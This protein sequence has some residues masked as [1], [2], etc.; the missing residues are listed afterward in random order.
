VYFYRDSPVGSDSQFNPLT[1]FVNYGF[2]ALQVRRSFDEEDFQARWGQVWRNLWNPLGAIREEGGLRAF[3]NRQVLPVDPGALGEVGVMLPN[4]AL[5]LLGGG[6]LYRKNA[7]WL[8]TR[9]YPYPRTLAALLGMGSEVLQEVFEKK[10]TT[11]EDEV[12]D[13]WLFR[14]AG[15]LLFTWNPVARLAARELGMV[16]WP[17]QAVY[18]AGKGRFG[19]GGQSY[20]VRPAWRLSA[21][22]LPFVYFGMTTLAG[23]S[24]R[25]ASGDRVSWGGGAA[26]VDA[27]RTSAEVR[28]SAGLFWDRRGSL[29][30][31]LIVNGTEGLAA[32]LNVHPGVLGS[33][34]WSPGLYVGVEDGGG[35][36]AGAV[37]RWTPVGW[38]VAAP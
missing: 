1:S 11:H 8:Q 38:G 34:P 18:L 32:R 14:P 33:G 25:L 31:S 21:D 30:A 4:Y 24:H 22:H 19:N 16:E 27:R 6:M 5:H 20:A 3:F 12:A 9:G 10:S 17:Y 2:D 23:F 7:E 28:P 29:L 35:V 15:V 26:V 13:V 36:Q 37:L